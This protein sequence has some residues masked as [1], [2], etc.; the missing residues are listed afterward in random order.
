MAGNIILYDLPSIHKGSDKPSCFSLNPWKTRMVLNYK[1]IPYTTEWVE[2]PDLEPK[3]KELGVKANQ[4]GTGWTDYT[5]PTIRLPDGKVIMNSANIAP[6]LEE[7][8]PSPPLHL[9]ADLHGPITEAVENLA[10]VVWWDTLADVPSMLP[11]RSAKYFED[12][13]KETFGMTLKEFAAVKGGEQAWKTAAE[14]GGAAEKLGDLLTKHRKDEGPFVLGS[15][16]SYGDF[17]A[18][19]FFDCFERC[20]K[21]DYEKMMALDARFKPLHAACRPWL[22]RDD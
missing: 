4:P 22:K 20:C 12:T 2:Y 15:Q 16:P 10:G 21:E 5:S 7:L 11:P 1:Q 13:R 17:V 19:S 9:D 14:P 3:M 18:A 8:H 6:V